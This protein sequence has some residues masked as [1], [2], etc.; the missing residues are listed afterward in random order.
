MS[1][2]DSPETS[3]TCPHRT[4]PSTWRPWPL[5]YD[6]QSSTPSSETI[7]GTNLNFAFLYR[8]H[9]TAPDV[10]VASVKSGVDSLPC[11]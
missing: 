7:D 11:V 5:K 4:N 1:A 10:P 6:L 2:P 8:L 9:S 3:G